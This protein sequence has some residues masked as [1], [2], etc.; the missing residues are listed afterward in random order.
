MAPKSKIIA[1][2]TPDQRT[3]PCEFYGKV[4]QFFTGEP[5]N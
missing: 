4:F 2:P 3:H 1:M 5:S